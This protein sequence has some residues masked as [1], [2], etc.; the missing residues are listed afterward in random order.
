MDGRWLIL[1]LAAC[2]GAAASGEPH[3]AAVIVTD[4]PRHGI[5]VP[6][7]WKELPTIGDAATETAIA[8]LGKD[9]VVHTHAWGEPARGCYL[10][11]VDA[12]GVLRD[13]TRNF[14]TELQTALTAQVDVQEWSTSP[15]N[16]D[17]AEVNARFTAVAA[18]MTGRARVVMAVDRRKVPHAVAAACFY[19]D[20]QP[21]VCDNAC[22]P[23]LAQLEPLTASPTPG[24]ATP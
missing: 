11:I 8:I 5:D 21:A 20:R 10:T 16:E 6:A 23:L 1:A 13:T 24:Q 19:N 9:A 12:T 15:D 17:T 7:D 3:D 18:G 2:R 4:E 14:L 22:V